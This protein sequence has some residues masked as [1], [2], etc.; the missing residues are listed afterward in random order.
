M[1]SNLISSNMTLE[2][3]AHLKITSAL[4]LLDIFSLFP[5]PSVRLLIPV[6]LIK[7]DKKNKNKTRPYIVKQIEHVQYKMFFCSF[8][9]YVCGLALEGR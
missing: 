4:V 9:S 3:I 7:I 8:V 1:H 5:Y 6:M 2:I